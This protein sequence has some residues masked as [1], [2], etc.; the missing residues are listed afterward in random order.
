MTR[1]AT[2]K[3][4]SIIVPLL[5]EA[6]TITPFLQRLDRALEGCGPA[7]EVIFVDDGSS[8]ATWQ[9]L[10][11]LHQ[12]RNN[13]TLISLS[14]RFGKDV[15]LFAGMDQAKGDAV[16]VMDGD[17]QDPPE[18]IPALIR[19]FKGMVSWIGFPREYVAYRREP[20]YR[21]RS[22]WTYLKLT[23]FALDAVTSFSRLPLRGFLATGT[24]AGVVSVFYGLY[25]LASIL[26]GSPGSPATA[27]LLL[28]T[29]LQMVILCLMGEYLA[30]L[31]MEA[32]QRPLY[33]VHSLKKSKKPLIEHET[34]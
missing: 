32:K 17:L 3:S 23:G 18:I 6:E 14:R 30:H 8:D 5:N 33:I 34:V 25:L 13:I 4:L 9:K 12:V 11:D 29:G 2:Q 20:R 22:K 7:W 27:L 10:L 16:V 19:Y 24:V 21:G 15:A 26:T 31:F 1:S 28:L